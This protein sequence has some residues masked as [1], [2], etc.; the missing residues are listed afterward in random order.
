[1]LRESVVDDDDVLVRGI[2]G[3]SEVTAF[4]PIVIVPIRILQTGLRL[5]RAISSFEKAVHCCGVLY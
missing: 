3:V 4:G 5:N 2:V 1:V